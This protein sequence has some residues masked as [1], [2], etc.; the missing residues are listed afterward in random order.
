MPN[1]LVHTEAE[2][3]NADAHPRSAV[4]AIGRLGVVAGPA[5]VAG[6]GVVAS[7]LVARRAAR[8][9]ATSTAITD[10]AN[11]LNEAFVQHRRSVVGAEWHGGGAA[12]CDGAN[13]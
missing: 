6:L 4:I 11:I 9:P 5:I 12:H 13:R 1:C 8:V 7:R 10:G 2:R 3:A